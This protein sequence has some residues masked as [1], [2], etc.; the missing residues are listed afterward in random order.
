MC[1]FICCRFGTTK[2]RK[3]WMYDIELAMSN[4]TLRLMAEAEVNGTK[5]PENV[6]RPSLL[7]RIF[8]L[9]N[10]LSGITPSPSAK[11]QQLQ[12]K[13]HSSSSLLGANNLY[14]SGS[15]VMEE[16]SDSSSSSSSSD[17]SGSDGSDSDENNG[18]NKKKPSFMNKSASNRTNNNNSNDVV[19]FH[20]TNKVVPVS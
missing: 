15:R 1:L 6:Q 18:S 3:F 12:R 8:T 13:Q 10:R 14:S 5:L 4:N 20:A 17:D 11:L 7:G 2:S 16:S 19:P 9:S